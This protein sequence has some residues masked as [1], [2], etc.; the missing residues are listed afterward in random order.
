MPYLDHFNDEDKLLLIKLPYRTGLW[1][2]ASDTTG[3]DESD[4]A[5]RQAL[6]NI[7]RGFT[8]DFLKSEFVEEVMRETVAHMGEWDNWGEN[9]EAIPGEIREGIAL[10]ARHIDYKQM[11]AFKGSLM[12]VAMTVAMAYREMDESTPFTQQMRIYSRY[13]LERVRAYL[14]KTQPPIMD[15]FLNIS[16]DE[17]KA[18]D[19]LSAALRPGDQE[20]VEPVEQEDAA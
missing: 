1:V 6:A 4:E 15:Q 18:L 3:G 20:G 19:I 11:A 5:E 10:A 17:H 8:E 12:D 13:W 7:V 14:L 9:I 16:Q 2:S